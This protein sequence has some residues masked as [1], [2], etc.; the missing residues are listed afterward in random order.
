MTTRAANS[1]GDIARACAEGGPPDWRRGPRTSALAVDSEDRRRAT[2][3][4]SPLRVGDRRRRDHRRRPQ[5]VERQSKPAVE[6]E[7]SAA[8]SSAFVEAR[9]SPPGRRRHT[10]DWLR[11]PDA[12]F[13]RTARTGRDRAA[14]RAVHRGERVSS[15]PGAPPVAHPTARAAPARGAASGRRSASFGGW[16]EASMAAQR[17]RTPRRSAGICPHQA[18]CN[19]RQ[20]RQCDRRQ[21]RQCGGAHRFRPT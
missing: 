10:P 1:S 2:G 17:R 21:R 6:P 7:C 13:S 12:C 16:V 18:S 9:L 3:C 11:E 4:G 20:R 5:R 8:S 15:T 19:Q 14:P